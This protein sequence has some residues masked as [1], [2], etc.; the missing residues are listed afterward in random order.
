MLEA[1][2]RR[3]AGSTKFDG[4]SVLVCGGSTGLTGAPSL[5]A[6]G[7]MRAGAGYVTAL[8]AASLHLVFELRRAEMMSVPLP[9][10]GGSLVP[11]ALD[12]VLE[13]CERADALVLGPG[14]GRAD[15]AAA[16]AREL[17]AAR[18]AAV[19]AR[20]RRA[21]RARQRRLRCARGAQRPDG[22]DAARRRAGAAARRVERRGP[23]AA[24]RLR[25]RGGR[26]A[27]EP[28]SC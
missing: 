13:R 16:F 26:G 27:P 10:D 21:E 12:V 8:V 19:A 9:D 20:R 14:L 28:S 2:P 3:E 6:E 24:A 4:G 11:E 23:C 17:A 22:P 25:A 5:A 1:L 15:G 7:A 18:A